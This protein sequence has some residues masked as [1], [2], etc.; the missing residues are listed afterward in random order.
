MKMKCD[1]CIH[2]AVY[3]FKPN[4]DYPQ[5]MKRI[6]SDN[7]KYFREESNDKVRK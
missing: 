7:C 4:E 3:K 5:F 6:V 1:S 2:K